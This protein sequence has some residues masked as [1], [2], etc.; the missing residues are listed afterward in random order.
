MEQQVWINKFNL[1]KEKYNEFYINSNLLLYN[2]VIKQDKIQYSINNTIYSKDLPNFA[3][4]KTENRREDYPTTNLLELSTVSR[5]DNLYNTQVNLENQSNYHSIGRNICLFYENSFTSNFCELEKRIKGSRCTLSTDD[6]KLY[7]NLDTKEINKVNNKLVS[8]L[9]EAFNSAK[10][11]VY[12]L[13]FSS[14]KFDKVK[15]LSFYQNYQMLKESLLILSSLSHL[16]ND[17]KLLIDKLLNAICL[18]ELLFTLVVRDKYENTVE[19][20]LYMYNISLEI[21]YDK[22]NKVTS[23]NINAFLSNIPFKSTDLSYNNYNN[24]D[25]IFNKPQFSCLLGY[26]GFNIKE[27][28]SIEKV[29]QLL[30]ILDDMILEESKTGKIKLSNYDYI[31]TSI[32]K[33]FSIKDTNDKADDIKSIFTFTNKAQSTLALSDLK[34]S[35]LNSLF[36][37]I[38]SKI[39]S[40]LNTC[41]LEKESFQKQIILQC[42]SKNVSSHQDYFFDFILRKTINKTIHNKSAIRVT[43]PEIV[44]DKT[45]LF[46]KF[47]SFLNKLIKSEI[48]KSYESNMMNQRYSLKNDINMIVLKSLSNN[49]PLYDHKSL[50]NYMFRMNKVLSTSENTYYFINTSNSIL[51]NTVD[52][53]LFLSIC[54]S[55]SLNSYL[56]KTYIHELETAAAYKKYSKLI[57]SECLDY[58]HNMR[59]LFISLK[60]LQTIDFQIE[61][62]KNVVKLTNK[63][64]NYL[65]ELLVSCNTNINSI[66]VQRLISFLKMKLLQKRIK[67]KLKENKLTNE[68]E[69]SKAFKCNNF[70][71][72]IFEQKQSQLL[73]ETAN[74]FNVKAYIND[75]ISKVQ[76]RKLETDSCQNEPYYVSFVSKVINNAL[77]KIH[78]KSISSENSIVYDKLDISKYIDDLMNRVILRVSMRITIESK[79]IEIKQTKS[80][81]NSITPAIKKQNVTYNKYKRHSIKLSTKKN[82]ESKEVK[83]LKVLKEKDE[84]IIHNNKSSKSVNISKSMLSEKTDKQEKENESSE[85]DN[86]IKSILMKRDTSIPKLNLNF[87]LKENIIITKTS[88]TVQKPITSP[89]EHLSAIKIQSAFK[90]YKLRLLFLNL[91]YCVTLIQR[92]VR[93][94]FIKKYKLPDNYHYNE[95]Y[96]NMIKLH[97][98]DK[99]SSSFKIIYP[100]YFADNFSQSLKTSLYK[101]NKVLLSYNNDKKDLK[102]QIFNQSIERLSVDMRLSA[103]IIIKL[104]SFLLNKNFEGDL[105][106]LYQKSQAD[107]KSIENEKI[108]FFTKMLDFEQIIDVDDNDEFRF[109]ID[110]QNINKYN[111][112]NNSNIQSISIG[113][114]HSLIRNNKGKVYSF[115]WNNNG[116]CGV[117]IEST[118]ASKNYLKDR[119]L[120]DT[121]KYN[122]IQIQN[123]YFIDNNLNQIEDNN[124]IYAQTLYNL[125]N[126]Q[127]EP[128]SIN[129]DEI[130]DIQEIACGEEH[131]LMLDSKGRVWSCGDNSYGQ[132]GHS[133]TEK[134][135]DMPKIIKLD[136]KFTDIK[137]SNNTNFAISDEG[138]LFMWP[139]LSKTMSI[140]STPIKLM[141]DSNLKVNSISCG[142]NFVLINTI[143]GLVYSFGKSNAF[144]QL[145]HG[146]TKHRNK[147]T[148]I[149]YFS[150]RNIKVDQIGCGF[151]HCIAKTSYGKVY[152]WGLGN[153]GQLATKFSNNV[154]C[155]I[156][157]FNLQKINHIAAG[158]CS[159]YFMTDELKLYVSGGNSNYQEPI[160]I[161]Y[162]ERNPELVEGIKHPLIKIHSTWSKTY[163]VIYGTFADL[164]T[165]KECDYKKI[166]NVVATLSSNWNSS[167]TAPPL[168]DSINKYFSQKIKNRMSRQN[169]QKLIKN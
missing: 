99:I 56:D 95:K 60:L 17:E 120:I 27:I 146:D 164:R 115:G 2:G 11:E 22:N 48:S 65:E 87:N 70:F 53:G 125:F 102:Q 134:I 62:V 13:N 61:D 137:T 93:K 32:N 136:N 89:K 138:N 90:T 33:L 130:A 36:F 98:E 6:L 156:E 97:F 63:A 9:K 160:L 163:S 149:E 92:Q 50:T 24:N 121:N 122:E 148:L 116:Q 151:K 78:Q 5:F 142:Y 129:F 80:K 54:D 41:N 23:S 119:F 19:Q 139:T 155:L 131:S 38:I 71:W 169:S 31:T 140:V 3:I 147:P 83:D 96:L 26:F 168:I 91:K 109:P 49:K 85:N 15:D 77:N 107:K 100:Y 12:S 86:N 46:M 106:Q 157:Y 20:V 158:F 29:F 64:F 153:K 37:Q 108:T 145:G 76:V 18:L 88:S 39:N 68:I 143:N 128:K 42:F 152:S 79:P 16:N 74:E 166:S 101:I 133:L 8:I 103:E 167:K 51:Y 14:I 123:L 82:Q 72:E 47:S 10:D 66:M 162:E 150:T 161:N 59:E 112:N 30:T 105:S 69:E 111:I 57:F 25:I 52:H 1:N 135:I 44:I 4:I 40:N 81:N 126:H 114:H 45:E 127:A 28:S 73:N 117:D 21:N 43:I 94:Y 84:L 144:G 35:L 159:S 110:Y 34:F 58:T 7:C 132:L 67:E 141:I 124:D 104:Y 75:I 165:F 113:G 118:L 154:P 55:Y